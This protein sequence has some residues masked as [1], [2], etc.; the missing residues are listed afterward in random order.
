MK[1]IVDDNG[2]WEECN[3]EY[4]CNYDDYYSRTGCN[5]CFAHFILF[6]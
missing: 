3:I 4:D 1:A 5:R 2:S 6:L